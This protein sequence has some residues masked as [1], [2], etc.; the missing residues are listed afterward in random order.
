MSY[1]AV[2]HGEG[3]PDVVCLCVPR[4]AGHVTEQ[5]RRGIIFAKNA[6]AGANYSC[7][8]ARHTTPQHCLANG[9]HGEAIGTIGGANQQSILS[10]GPELGVSET[11]SGHWHARGPARFRTIQ[12]CPKDRLTLPRQA[13]DAS[14]RLRPA[15]PACYHRR[16]HLGGSPHAR[17][18]A[19][20]VRHTAPGGAAAAWP[21]TA[22]AQQ[23]VTTPRI[24]V[25]TTLADKD[26]RRAV[27][28]RGISSGTSE[29]RVD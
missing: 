7:V 8:R 10:A 28:G 9:R 4:N 6:V 14:N 12:V 20:G 16:R 21:L 23:S 13:P 11:L 19:T 25:L 24:G 15:V 1:H 27:A 18:E 5:P 17:H 26:F 22:R 3:C 29:A 2:R